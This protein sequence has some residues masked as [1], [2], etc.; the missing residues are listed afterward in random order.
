MKNTDLKNELIRA[1]NV[2][3]GKSYDFSEKYLAVTHVCS[4]AGTDPEI[5]R[6]ETVSVLKDLFSNA[7]VYRQT[8]AYFLHKVTAEALCRLAVYSQDALVAV[9]ARRTVMDLLQ[10]SKART[11]RA[12]AEALGS[13]HFTIEGPEIENGHGKNIPVLSWEELLGETGVILHD[14]P[15]FI[16]R[17]LV[18]VTSNPGQ[19]FVVKLAGTEHSQQSLR[20]ET[21]WLDHMGNEHYLFPVKFDIPQILKVQNSPLFRLKDIPVPIPENVTLH[22]DRHAIVFLTGQDYYLYPNESIPEK[23]LHPEAFKEVMFRNAFLFGNLSSLGILHSAPIPLFHNRVQGF[24]REDH[25][26]YEWQR[27]GR[28]DRWLESCLHPNFGLSGVR[29]FE[30]FESFTGPSRILYPHMGTQLLSLFLVTGS[31]FRGKDMNRVGFDGEGNPIDARDCFNKALLRELLDGI[32]SHYHRGFVGREFT[33]QAPMDL[34]MLSSRMVDEMGVD[35]FMEE[36]LRASDQQAMTDEAFLG[37]L[38]Q[39]G[40]SK[41]DANRRKRGEEDITLFTGPH[42]GGFNQRI[43]IPELI[44]SIGTMAA[45]CIYGKYCDLCDHTAS[46]H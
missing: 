40:F 7:A 18:G 21:D 4:L 6:L 13:L 36:I 19:I 24:R 5:F 8:Q 45:L 25:G 12:V 42:L 3:S 10:T 37:F 43:S 14:P 35:R 1:E 26:L 44:D 22:P 33:G 30:H 32:F 16:G 15:V 20:A 23:R 29:D 9:E 46:I 38:D 28:L 41:E 34:D 11:H 31:Y 17:S 2:L 27:A 39:R